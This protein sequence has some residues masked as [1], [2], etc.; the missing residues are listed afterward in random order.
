MTTQQVETSEARVVFDRMTEAV[1]GGKLEDLA[2]LYAA[3][4]V[5]STPEG[6]IRGNEQIVAYLKQ[7]VDAF[8]DLHWE[9]LYTHESGNTAVDEG[10]VVGTHTQPLVMPNGETL[11]PTGRQLRLRECD[12]VTVEGGRITS[13]RFYYDQMELL[14]Q[15]GVLPP[16]A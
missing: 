9:P 2:G 15:L 6:E 8:P 10:F 7:F 14:G 5:A 12:I 13:H 16:G 1:M 11:A 4:A 3:D